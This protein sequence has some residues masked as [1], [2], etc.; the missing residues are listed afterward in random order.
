MLIVCY[1]GV[2][3]LPA[4]LQALQTQT[5]QPAEV[6][7]VDSGTDGA[8][9]WVAQHHPRV[10]VHRSSRRMFPGEARNVA[11][12]LAISDLVAFLDADCVPGEDWVQRIVQAHQAGD[13]PSVIGGSVA[14][15][16]DGQ[17]AWASYLCEFA[18]WM[19]GASATQMS[20]VPTC[21]LSAPRA[22]FVSQPFVTGTYCSDTAWNWEMGR[23][24]VPI[25]FE[26]Q[27]RVAHL[28]HTR[29]LSWLRKNAMHGR[30]FAR[31]RV[32]SHRFTR[33]RSAAFTMGS[34]L[35]PLVLSWRTARR[36]L[37]QRGYAAQLLRA[38]PLVILGHIAW[39][40]GE[41][42]GYAEWAAQGR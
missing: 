1:Q 28:G 14:N 17:T 40:A 35:L 36:V 31:V 27:I 4:V 2:R 19:P 23:R 22:L 20:D 33:T 38:L 39:S 5:M 15:G 34:I 6:I 13:G 12:K 26:P 25:R 42:A 16:A 3:T 10:R 37:R 32:A 11:V 29:T 41:C 7:L 24:G 30:A 8:A 21:T 9:E 18:T